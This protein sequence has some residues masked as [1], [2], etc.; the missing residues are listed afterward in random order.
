MR[1][2]IST[3]GC[4]DWDLATILDRF[5]AYGCQGIDFRGIG[6]QLDITLMPEFLQDLSVTAKR[7]ADAGLTVS[8]LSTSIWLCDSDKLRANLEEARRYIPIAHALGVKNMRVFGGGPVPQIGI[9]KAAAVGA[10]TLQQIASLPGAESLNWLLET[11]D[12]WSRSQDCLQLLHL[13]AVHNSG[14]IWDIEHTILEGHENP[15]NTYESCHDKII[16]VHIKDAI[17]DSAAKNNCRIVLP[18]AGELPLNE[19]IR[20][21]NH[22]GYDGWYMFEHEKRWQRHLEEPDIAFPAYIQ[23]MNSL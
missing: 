9:A 1:L 15:V 6:N 13:A 23:W 20:R 19:C 16:Y 7:I 11:H 18:G 2:S 10:R 14:L 17:A 22:G 3:L 12:H 8:G 5:S 21:L 4:P